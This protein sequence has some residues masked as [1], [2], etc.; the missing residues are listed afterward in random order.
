VKKVFNSLNKHHLAKLIK[1]DFPESEN[2]GDRQAEIHY[3]N[4]ETNKPGI[5]VISK[6][7]VI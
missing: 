1:V 2:Q 4:F 3:V 7:K 6:D 5:L